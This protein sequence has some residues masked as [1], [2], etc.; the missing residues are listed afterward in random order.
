MLPWEGTVRGRV[1]DAQGRPVG[2]VDLMVRSAQ[3]EEITSRNPVLSP[4]L[5]AASAPGDKGAGG[6]SQYVVRRTISDRTG[7]FAFAGLPEGPHRIDVL[8]PEQ[9]VALWTALE[10]KVSVKVGQVTETTIRVDKGGVLEVMALDARTRRPI[11]LRTVQRRRTV[12]EPRS[13]C[14]HRRGRCG[15]YPSPG[16]YLQARCRGW[17]IVPMAGHGAGDRWAYGSL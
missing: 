9:G 4:S 6:T 17:T 16:G 11:A 1:V 13:I 14:D 12:V 7:A 8:P 5:R 10:S 2:G 3:G 15:T